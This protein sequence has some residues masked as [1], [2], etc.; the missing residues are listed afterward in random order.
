MST[1]VDTLYFLETANPEGKD[2]SYAA[3][4]VESR[5]MEAVTQWAINALKQFNRKLLSITRLPLEDEK[6]EMLR[7]IVKENGR[8][9]FLI[10]SEKFIQGIHV[11]R[12]HR[13]TLQAFAPDEQAQPLVAEAPMKEV[14]KR[15]LQ[16]HALLESLFADA[17][18]MG[19]GVGDSLRNKDAQN[20]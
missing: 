11:G 8:I 20:N 14:E 16:T 18:S 5:D 6:A 12:T 19:F 15:L 1:P 9:I 3:E 7:T 13:P 4:L 17:F 2:V 10:L